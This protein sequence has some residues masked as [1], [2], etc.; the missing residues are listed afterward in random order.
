MDMKSKILKELDS[1]IDRISNHKDDE[2]EDGGNAFVKLNQA[3]S[4]VLGQ[5]LKNEISDI[6]DFVDKL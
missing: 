2:K 4:K 1:R 3:V 5:T 6:R